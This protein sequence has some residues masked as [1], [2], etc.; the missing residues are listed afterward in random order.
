MRVARGAWERVFH[1]QS[2]RE[3]KK[4]SVNKQK[5][6]YC[7]NKG[8]HCISFDY[9]FSGNNQTYGWRDLREPRLSLFLHCCSVSILAILSG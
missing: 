5:S 2:K 1:W 9:F 4:V 7:G 3:A 6:R 8:L